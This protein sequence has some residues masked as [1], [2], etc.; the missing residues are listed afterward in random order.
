ML[1]A[2][3]PINM[4]IA[5]VIKKYINVFPPILPNFL[6]SPMLA[7]PTT[8]EANTS[9]TMVILMRFKNKVPTG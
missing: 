6:T 1:A 8:N 5:V 2:N 3:S 7:A 9:G 4:A